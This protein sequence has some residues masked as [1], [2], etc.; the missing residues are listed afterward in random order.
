M[1]RGSI[2]ASPGEQAGQSHLL[3]RARSRSETSSRQPAM[4]AQLRAAAAAA[5]RPRSQEVP[6]PRTAVPM[7]RLGPKACPVS[8]TLLTFLLLAT[9]S[10]HETEQK[11]YC[12]NIITQ[13]HLDK[14]QELIDSQML[15]PCR[16]SFEFIDEKQLE[17]SICFIKAAFP[18]LADILEKMQFKENS[19][20]FNKTRDVRAMYKKIDENEEPCISEQS[21]HEHEV[22]QACFKEFSVPPEEMLQ[23]VKDFFGK[24]MVHLKKGED[25][26]RDCST[27]YQKCSNSPQKE[28]PSPGVVTDH[29]CNC[30]SPSPPGAPHPTLVTKPSPSTLGS[31]HLPLSQPGT[32]P[33]PA[34]LLSSTRPRGHRSTHRGLLAMEMQGAWAGI[35]AIVSS[36][37][38]ELGPGSGAEPLLG[39]SDPPSTEYVSSS[40]ASLP[41]SGAEMDTG[42]EVERPQTRPTGLR[43][44]LHAP[45]SPV[46]SLNAKPT[47]PWTG[48]EASQA[49]WTSSTEELMDVSS[50]NAISSPALMSAALDALGAGPGDPLGTPLARKLWLIPSPGSKEP[51]SIMQHR[52][53]RMAPTVGSPPA[54]ERHPRVSPRL[55]AGQGRAPDLQHPTEPRGKRTGG[56]ASFREPE[57]RLA[58]PV[59]GFNILPP[60]ADQR[61]R[62]ALPR[63]S[64]WV[65]M[66]YVLVASLATVV[67]LLAVG[68]LLFYRHRVR[69]LE[70]RLQCR[71]NAGE[72]QEGRPLNGVEEHLEL[73]GQ[74]AL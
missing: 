47:Q 38:A 53:S 15:M 73:Q 63:E 42:T 36:P 56:Q 12:E 67:I 41:A 28:P 16:I 58:G 52:F 32:T 21:E 40:P 1:L 24:V 19:D 74:G 46:P 8:C 6:A 22:S 70:R 3:L 5:P 62:E 23:L 27:T 59:P 69:V 4:T 13:K 51:F 7:R 34:K 37:P 2:R 18:G 43:Q 35:S 50:A 68:G 71:G 11:G 72:E 61:R 30:P 33:A 57:D 54:P 20:N 29:D 45:G 10:I 66:T 17:D 64:R 65:V 48:Q 55:P 39:L 9:C 60:N 26:A 25:F 14:L 44:F 31:T 49:T